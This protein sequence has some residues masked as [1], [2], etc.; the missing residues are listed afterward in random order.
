MS[1]ATGTQS[2]AR[3]ETSAAWAEAEAPNKSIADEVEHNAEVL[4]NAAEDAATKAQFKSPAAAVDQLERGMSNTTN[5]AA[6]EGKSN[7]QGYVQQVKDL[8]NSAIA[9]A[10]SYLPSSGSTTGISTARA[11]DGPSTTSNVGQTVAETATAAFATGKQYAT[12]AS[13]A[14]A[15]VAQSAVGAGLSAM[16]TAK[17]T[18]APYVQSAVNAVS[19]TNTGKPTTETPAVAQTTAPL[20]SGPHIV[21]SPYPATTTGQSTKV[22]EV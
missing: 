4:H 2:D 16:E 18:A 19:G 1:Q 9:T 11:T 8:A 6:A 17:N 5:A 21:N 12:A 15:P 20:E 13:N 3:F 10:Q 22:G 7:V 14:A